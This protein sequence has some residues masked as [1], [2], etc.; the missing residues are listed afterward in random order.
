MRVVPNKI[1]IPRSSVVAKVAGA[2]L[3]GGVQYATSVLVE[4]LFVFIQNAE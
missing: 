4:R 1:E 2:R 3:G